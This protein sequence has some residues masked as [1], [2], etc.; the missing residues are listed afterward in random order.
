MHAVRITVLCDECVRIEYA[1]H[2]RFCDHPS[3]FAIHGPAGPDPI[4]PRACPSVRSCQT[5]SADAGSQAIHVRTAR[6]ELIYVP[7]GRP[8][9]D[10]NMRAHI[11]HAHAPPDVTREPITGRV[12]WTPGMRARHNLG[13]TLSTLDGLRGA[14]PLGEGL[15]SRDGWHVVD[16]SA[17]HLLVDDWAVTR[18]SLGLHHNTDHY[19]FAYG[20]DYAAALRA[21]AFIAGRVPLPRRCTLGSW[22]SRYWPYTSDEY[23]GIVDEFDRH[24]FPLDVL[25]LDMD[26]HKPGWTGWSWNRELI[27]D[28]EDFIAWLHARGLV[29]TLNL[30]PADGVGPHE[31]RYAAFMRAIGREPDGST[32]RFDAGDRTYMRALFEIVHRPLEHPRSRPES[33]VD[34]WWVDWQ[35]DK[36][37]RS[38]PGLTHLRWLNHL[39]ARH[40]R[41]EPVGDDPGLRAQPFS[42]WAG[43]EGPPDAGCEWGVPATGGWGD[44]RYPV[45][46]SGDAHTGWAMLD[47]QIRMTV[48]A[49]NIGCF[50]WSHDIG[51]HFGP[52]LEEAMT[53]WVQF[54]AVSAALRLHSARSPVLDRRPWTYEERFTRAMR[55]AFALRSRLMPYIYTCAHEAH[56]R[57]LPL[58][59]PMYL[60]HPTTEIAYR[61]PAQYTIG[62]DLLCAPI[63]SPG[64]AEH[65]VAHQY[66]WFPSDASA[67][68][69][70]HLVTGE[71]FD[72]GSEAV[73]GAPSDRFPVFVRSGAMLPMRPSTARMTSDPLHTLVLCAFPGTPGQVET[74]V[75][76]EDDGVS[77]D[78][79][80]GR[81]AVT[82][83]QARW[84]GEQQRLI[85]HARVEPTTGS[86]CGQLP[87]RAVELRLLG[88]AAV[89]DVRVDDLP[90]AWSFDE[91]HAGGAMIVHVPDR[92]IRR[93]LHIEAVCVPADTR[94]INHRIRADD[95]TLVLGRSTSVAHLRAD[96]ASACEPGTDRRLPPADVLA[97]GAGIGASIDDHTLRIVDTF[98]SA[99]GSQVVVEF[100]DRLGRHER[101]LERVQRVLEPVGTQARAAGI[102]LPPSPIDA[103]PVGVS[104]RRVARVALTLDQGEVAFER[105]IDEVRTPLTRFLAVG[106]FAWDW[107]N[108]IA[109]VV[110]PPETVAFDPAASFVDRD[111]RPAHWRPVGPGAKWPV[112]LRQTLHA[113]GGLAC[114]LTRVTSSEPQRVRLHVDCGDKYEVFTRELSPA[115]ADSTARSAGPWTKV[116]THNGFDAHAAGPPYMEI[117]LPR[118]ES[119]VMIKLCDGGGGWGAHVTIDAPHPLT[120]D[121]PG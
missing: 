90:A 15:L 70:R 57:T 114:M 64:L 59:R 50:Y 101:L 53:R 110:A 6:F 46:F 32:A 75:L 38:I 115:G 29:V 40:T 26:W 105:L 1:P 109:D 21:L 81:C 58:L 25:V 98:G 8:P 120:H 23:R 10:G 41:R 104:A 14:H 76:Y 116:H 84:D 91:Q 119:L 65:C 97:I 112:D 18:E 48:T 43:D 99:K 44:H 62:R 68:S 19:L 17:R 3:L 94:L 27:P 117:D 118:G 121:A 80:R 7:D 2:G 42:R 107:R 79:E 13:G 54:G 85:L 22:Y 33:G 108:A 74:S 37:V 39:Y 4:T 12:L 73:V 56:E 100:I 45:H 20:N 30:H 34:F 95:L 88:V 86:F 93:P 11:E 72:A 71:S 113:R 77:L 51:G 69:W 87:T 24:D 67:R 61:A 102:A 55:S 35:Q 111:Q 28:P 63:A 52:R 83:I 103:P 16:D 89:L 36:F 78:H 82:P 96:V 47:F 66:V 31:D 49:G 5:T 92:D 9:H 60:H 106:P